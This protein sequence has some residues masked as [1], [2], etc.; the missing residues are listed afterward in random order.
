MRYT[1]S[2]LLLT[3]LVISLLST[4][5]GGLATPPPPTVTLSLIHI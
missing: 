1:V 2:G 3:L 4:G 5:C